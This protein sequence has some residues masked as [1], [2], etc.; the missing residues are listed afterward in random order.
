MKTSD[1]KQKKKQNKVLNYPV[2]MMEDTFNYWNPADN[3]Y[4]DQDIKD[5]YK[6]TSYDSRDVLMLQ[7]IKE[8]KKL[9]TNLSAK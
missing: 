3:E 1:M 8:L 7:L 2:G 6:N 9:N 4:I 5:L